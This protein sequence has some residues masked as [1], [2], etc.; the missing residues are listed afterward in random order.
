MSS[1][2]QPTSSLS[3]LAAG[4]QKMW[5][6]F[7]NGF[8]QQGFKVYRLSPSTPAA[9]IL[10][11]TPVL[12]IPASL[13]RTVS[14]GA[15]ENQLF[16]L[17]TFDATCDNS[18][19]VLGDILEYPDD[20]SIYCYAQYRPP[21]DPIFVRC[22]APA[23][24]RRPTDAAS[25]A[26]GTVTQWTA[27]TGADEVTQANALAMTVTNGA[28]AFVAGGSTATIPIGIQPTTRARPGHAEAVPTSTSIERFVGYA[29]PLG[30]PSSAVP[31]REND[32]F[33]IQDGSDVAYVVEQVYAS[34]LVGLVGTVML[35]NKIGA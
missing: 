1:V 16:E 28:Y 32:V 5:G 26:V 10:S 8:G 9:G 19:L 27:T 6:G 12:T 11:G 33:E 22:D 23:F 30:V 35:L 17:V 21:E 20:G 14:R 24:L 15:L 34:G 29:P 7:A 2:P 25:D 13:K 31:I 4:L 3:A 18:Q